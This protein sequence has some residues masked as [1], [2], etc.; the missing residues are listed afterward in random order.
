MLLAP[1]IV[2]RIGE[3]WALRIAVDLVGVETVIVGA[4]NHAA[5]VGFALFLATFGSL[6]WNVVAVPLRRRVTPPEL[7]GR[8]NSVYRFISWGV[9][10]L[11]AIF[12][13]VLVKGFDQ[14]TSYETA[15]RAP[16]F[17]LGGLFFV[18]RSMCFSK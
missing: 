8:V 6:L 13:G 1:K 12:A 10:P 18:P 4:A 15:L 14:F 17:V 5:W 3:G 9:I 2:G 11:G 7:L 16:Y